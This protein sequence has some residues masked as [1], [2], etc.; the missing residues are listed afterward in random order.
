MSQPSFVSEK[1]LLDVT[2][3]PFVF[4]KSQ[5]VQ[6]Q[7]NTMGFILQ[8]LARKDNPDKT[9][10]I[11][12]TCLSHTGIAKDSYFF[13]LAR[14]LSDKIDS[15]AEV[16]YEGRKLSFSGKMNYYHNYRH[17]QEVILNSMLLISINDAYGDV[18][19]SPEEKAFLLFA[20]LIHD[21]GHDG[22]ANMKDGENIPY[23]LE[24]ISV[25]LASPDIQ[26]VLGDKAAAF[27]TDL[28]A[29]IYAT[30]IAPAS[31]ILKDILAYHRGRASKKPQF[32]PNDE[33][34]RPL[35][36]NPNLAEVAA[37][38]CDADI[39]FSIAYNFACTWEASINLSK[40]L[41]GSDALA[42]N[43]LNAFYDQM[44]E[45]KS[46]AGEKLRPNFDVVKDSS[47]KML[48]IQNLGSSL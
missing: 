47:K 23:R 5:S 2:K 10:Q 18:T 1:A 35:K 37:M 30:D 48:N 7:G 14:R 27:I 17:M 39:A 24:K 28:R 40:E 12:H 33:V 6:S 25:E 15:H 29:V 31:P 44:A 26:E 43:N 11:I 4:N 21:L 42:L 16:E 38:L 9:W 3:V 34:F 8:L 20:S 45:I 22:T 41:T 46:L 36:E 13:P 19:L 32:T